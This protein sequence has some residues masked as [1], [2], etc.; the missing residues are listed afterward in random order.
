[1]VYALEPGKLP[2]GSSALSVKE[3]LPP[4][5]GVPLMVIEEPVVETKERPGGRLPELMDHCVD[6]PPLQ[7]TCTE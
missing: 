2:K 3:K 4:R 6:E 1:M 7:L 5:V